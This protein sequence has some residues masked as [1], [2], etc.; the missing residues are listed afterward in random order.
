MLMIVYYF[1]WMTYLLKLGFITA[2]ALSADL[3]FEDVANDGRYA[4]GAV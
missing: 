1:H 2:F 4:S 3:L